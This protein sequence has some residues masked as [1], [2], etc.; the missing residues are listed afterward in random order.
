MGFDLEACRAKHRFHA[1]A[2][3]HPPIRLVV[4][5]AVLDEMQL[6]IGRFVELRNCVK[7]VIL[8]Y[9]HH[10]SATALHTLENDEVL[11]Y[12]LMN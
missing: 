2:I 4:R 8:F 10:L 3:R 11:G 12:M 1:S 5:V 9:I 7:V 6:W